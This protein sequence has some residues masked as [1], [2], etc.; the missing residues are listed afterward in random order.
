[1]REYN[2]ADI[3]LRRVSLPG[4]ICVTILDAGE[5]SRPSPHPCLMEHLRAGTH[6]RLLTLSVTISCAD[7]EQNSH[8][9]WCDVA[10]LLALLS[11]YLRLLIRSA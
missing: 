1:M 4:S 3:R 6:I 2:R 7:Y 9:Y 8:R 10:V 5:P 11:M